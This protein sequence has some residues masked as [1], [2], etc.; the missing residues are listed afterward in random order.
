MGM[1]RLPMQCV[2]WSEGS[3]GR[4]RHHP[5]G[6]PLRHDSSTADRSGRR[7]FDGVRGDS[8]LNRNVDE[9]CRRSRC[10]GARW[11]A[12][13]RSRIVGAG[14]FLSNDPAPLRVPALHASGAGRGISRAC[15]ALACHTRH[16]AVGSGGHRIKRHGGGRSGNDG[17]TGAALHSGG[18]RVGPGCGVVPGWTVPTRVVTLLRVGARV[19]QRRPGGWWCGR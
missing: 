11:R 17:A 16:W 2:R 5:I 18:E 6:W 10:R 12:T 9:R 4:R 19:V 3:G 7:R 15:G 8:G 1:P 14:P 13:Q